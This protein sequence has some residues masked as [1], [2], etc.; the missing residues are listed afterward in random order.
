MNYIDANMSEDLGFHDILVDLLN[1]LST[2]K[3]LSEIDN[4]QK[5][6]EKELVLNALNILITNQDMERCSF[7]IKTEQ[8]LLINL[9]GLSSCEVTNGA[10]ENHQ[11]LTFKIGEG[12]I[13]IAAKTGVLQNCTDCQYDTRFSAVQDDPTKRPG[14][15][16]SVPIMVLGELYGVLNISHPEAHYFSD[17]H[18]RLMEIYK[19]ILGQLISNYRLF[20]QMEQQ[21]ELKTAHLQKA[22][23]E[24]CLLKQ[25]FEKLSMIDTLTGLYNRRYFYAQAIQS[26]AG[27][28]RYG[29]SLC[30]LLLDLDFFKSVND[31]YG[32]Q[33][34]DQVLVSVADT[35]KGE[36]RD[37]D[38]VAR[39]G[40][41]EFVVL[42]SNTDCINGMIFAERIRVVIAA[43]QWEFDNQIVSITTSI[44][45]YCISQKVLQDKG[46]DIDAFIHCADLAM[47]QAKLNGRNQ[48]V[49]F[50]EDFLDK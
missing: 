46:D 20:Q 26:I 40:G 38:V 39:F 42:F 1:S 4:H 24:A 16:I 48:V 45:M 25:R 3:A 49:A 19:N 43:L 21:I 30:L 10:H 6:N 50:R 27:T 14:S 33:A 31:H 22:L 8:D 41:E 13:G 12:V 18:V 47:Y 34:G 11:S 36:M 28:E 17:W 37:S 32:H 44:G 9:T 29:D 7:F 23:D 35:L 2:V 5:T 15:I